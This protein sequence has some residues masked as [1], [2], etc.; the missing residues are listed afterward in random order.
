MKNFLKT[1]TPFVIVCL[2][3]ALFVGLFFV[4]TDLDKA[5]AGKWVGFSFTVLAFVIAGSF[6][7]FFQLKSK[8]T[9]TAMWAPIY[10]TAGY[11]AVTFLVNFIVMLV[12]SKSWKGAVV[13]NIII[14]VLYAIVFLV[15]YKS[16]SRVA[17]NTAVREA[18]MAS[19]R[20]LSI[21]VNALT[22]LA[23]DESV[24]R[25]IKTLKEDID[26]SSSAG[27][28]ATASYEQQLEDYVVTIQSVLTSPAYT[29][30]AALE[31]IANMAN[32]LKVRNQLLMAT[33]K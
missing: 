7:F 20:E 12:N 15:S 19:L 18:R 32:I 6:A 14:L 10:A 21:K 17:D 3:F 28:S 16:F 13:L 31:A 33:R 29:E 27:T 4:F 11:F 8:N 26:Y 2:V 25:A 5:N 30:E 1:K 23:K 22:F 9:M 24:K